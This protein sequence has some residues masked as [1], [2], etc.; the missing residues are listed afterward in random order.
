VTLSHVPTG[1]FPFLCGCAVLL[2]FAFF[3]GMY[4]LIYG[5]ILVGR[6]AEM[7]LGADS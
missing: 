5:A 2:A 1:E 6:D 7:D 4:R 3:F